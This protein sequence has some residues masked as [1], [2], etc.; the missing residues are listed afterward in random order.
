EVE[1]PGAHP[2]ARLGLGDGEEVGGAGVVRARGDDAPPVPGREL[3]QA[4]LER[5]A[6]RPHLGLDELGVR[7]QGRLEAL[8]RALEVA[9]LVLGDAGVEGVAGGHPDGDA[10]AAALQ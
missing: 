8:Q 5:Y 10:L 3:W 4:E 2:V 7:G 1:A 9:G 6:P